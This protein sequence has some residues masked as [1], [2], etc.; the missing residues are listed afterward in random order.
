MSAK[1]IL[2]DLFCGRGGWSDAA[3]S[4][5]CRCIGIDIADLGYRHEL[6]RL[7]LP[8][9]NTALMDF[10]PTIITAS[11]PC[12]DFARW[13]MP[14]GG[15]HNAGTFP[16]GQR[17][18]DGTRPRIPVQPPDPSLLHWSI[19]TANTINVPMIVECSRFAALYAPGYA[20]CGPYRLWGDVPPL[21][22]Q[23]LPPKANHCGKGRQP[24]QDRAAKRAMIPE[25]LAITCLEYLLRRAR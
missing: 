13:H 2:L 9:S 17:R 7:S 10:K 25:Y 16:I 8:L 4:L 19:T 23:R 3:A 14:W 5:G 15:L 11:P 12:E 18:S 21:L 20:R 24:T 22:P 6:H 1:P